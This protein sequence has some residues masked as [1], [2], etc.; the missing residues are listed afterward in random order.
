[1]QSILIVDDDSDLLR[2]LSEGLLGSFHVETASDPREAL[3]KLRTMPELAV[4]VADMR[5]P[6]MSG[7]ELLRQARSI[8]PNASRMMLTA[9]G[10][11][12]TAIAAI[13]EGNVCRFLTKPCGLPVLEAA[14]REALDLRR[15]LHH[16][17]EAQFRM[18]SG[19]IEVLDKVIQMVH[20]ESHALAQRL[21]QRMRELALEMLQPE[22]WELEIAAMLAPLGAVGA[23][24]SFSAANPAAAFSGDFPQAA[25]ALLR[26]IPR[27][28]KIAG[29]VAYIGKNFDGSG[30]PKDRVAG[31]EIPIGS[32]MLRVVRDMEERMGVGCAAGDALRLMQQE[33]GSYDP[34]V[35]AA[36][37]ACF[38][39]D[40]H[41]HLPHSTSVAWSALQEGDTLADDI[42]S[43]TG[44]LLLTK[45][46]RV[47]PNLK[48]MLQHMAGGGRMPDG[49]RI[50]TSNRSDLTAPAALAAE[51]SI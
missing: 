25:A 8:V 40:P 23:P 22:F 10:D 21:R 46:C 41:A 28:E 17:L 42:P 51:A 9:A 18:V 35:L 31:T 15:T 30:Q 1:M 27:M 14:I 26:Q 36:A 38:G 48:K 3:V 19:I 34:C 43:E 13:N 32:R 49:V 12:Q 50:R 37:L 5:M 2:A 4:V 47:T 11:A 6:G 20:P 44:A 24:Q 39:E 29:M 7:L 16:L 33:E 45:G